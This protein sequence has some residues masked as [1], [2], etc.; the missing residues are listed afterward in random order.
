M[1]FSIKTIKALWILISSGL[2]FCQC[3]NEKTQ[4]LQSKNT[5]KYDTITLVEESRGS[6]FNVTVLQLPLKPLM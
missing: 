5:I 1:F 3:Y 6:L 2:F 4:N